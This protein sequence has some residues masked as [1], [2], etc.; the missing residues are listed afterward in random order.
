ME[1]VLHVV[2]VFQRVEQFLHA[3]GV[4]CAQCHRVF[5][6]H[7][8][9]GQLGLKAGRLQGIS[10]RLEVR[11]IGQH[12]DG[13]VGVAEHVQCARFQ[14]HL[15]HPVFRAAGRKHQLPAVLELERHRALDSQL[16]AVFG[17][18]VPHLGHRAH[19]V[20]GHGVNDDGRAA[21][22]VAFVADFFQIHPFEGA[23][24]F[25]DVVLDAVG[26]HVGGLGFLNRQPQ[27]RVHSRIAAALARGNRDFTDDARPHLAAL[28]V[29][30]PLA[31]LNI[32]PFAVSSHK[33][34]RFFEKNLV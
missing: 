17:E 12:L 6:P 8:H 16:A 11:H 1:N 9:L 25:V 20:V 31:V 4:F 3:R 22:A 15:H 28:F 29:L 19:P 27:A 34:L 23:R 2:Q 26:R 21:D 32:G 10:H 14:R 33:R 18:S 24:C 13:A 5:G 30:T 7:G